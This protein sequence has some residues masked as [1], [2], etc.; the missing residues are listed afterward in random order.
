LNNPQGACATTTIDE[1]SSVIVKS[2]YLGASEGS[3]EGEIGELFVDVASFGSI[4]ITIFGTPQFD[5]SDLDTDSVLLVKESNKALK[6]GAPLFHKFK[7]PKQLNSH[8]HLAN[9]DTEP[10]I[11]W[12]FRENQVGFNVAENDPQTNQQRICV[13]GDQLSK[14]APFELCGAITVVSS[15]NS[16]PVVDMSC[17]GCDSPP[18]PTFFEAGK[19]EIVTYKAQATDIEDGDISDRIQWFSSVKGLIASNTDTLQ[20][21]ILTDGF[22]GS[23]LIS[24]QVTDNN[25]GT[26]IEIRKAIFGEFADFDTFK[27]SDGSFNYFAHGGSK[28]NK[29]L[30]AEFIVLDEANN[31]LPGVLATLNLLRNNAIIQTET[32]TSNAL[33]EIT[34]TKNN[35][36]DGEFRT[37]IVG[38]SSLSFTFDGS[39]PFPTVE[40]RT[41]I[42]VGIDLFA[43]PDTGLVSGV[44]TVLYTV[45]ASNNG[46]SSVSDVIST[47]TLPAG[48]TFV[49]GSSNCVNNSG[50]LTCIHG[51]IP[52]GNSVSMI[53][54]VSVDS[55]TNGLTISTTATY[56]SS[57]PTDISPDSSTVDIVVNP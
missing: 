36:A 21:N 52:A 10:D 9:E 8:I 44:S 28:A 24:A 32:V 20:F 17:D 7:N 4:S 42:P 16:I 33:G 45:T 37:S 40:E 48:L 54:T 11:T 23:H 30:S 29:H 55:G 6:V 26:G 15:F 53:Y 5:V 50:V 35:F 57:T 1:T 38:L 43:N 12:H 2:Q 34:I 51:S 47:V 27:I 49:P 19:D 14:Q 31:G 18:D 41:I 46:V 3:M 13:I 25:R 56:V 22:D 39:A